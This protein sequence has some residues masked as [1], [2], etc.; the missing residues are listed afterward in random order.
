MKVDSDM[1]CKMHAEAE[2]TWLPELATVMKETKDPFINVIY[3][4]DPLEKIVWDNI[5][6]VGDAAH[7]TTPHA[8]RSTNMSLVDAEVLGSCL[9]KWEPGNL[10][11]ALKE[12]QDIRIPVTSK[13]VLHARR[14]GQIKQ[15]LPLLDGKALDP[16]NS[17]PQELQELQQKNIPYFHAV[18]PH[19]DPPGGMD[20]GEK[21]IRV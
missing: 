17:S 21:E 8:L 20:W 18:P 11:V 2:R 10:L 15:R 19:L 1:I 12:Y 4:C 5:V 16:R 13:Q 3:D 9:T 7:P 14:L 6:L